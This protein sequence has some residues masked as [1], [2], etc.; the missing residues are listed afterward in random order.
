MALIE[1]KEGKVFY[2]DKEIIKIQIVGADADDENSGEY[3]VVFQ[4]DVSRSVS[5]DEFVRLSVLGVRIE[6]V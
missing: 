6:A 1:V 5:F 2:E 4:N 3:F